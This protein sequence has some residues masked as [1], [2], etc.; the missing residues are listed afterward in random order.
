MILEPYLL[1]AASLFCIGLYGILTS[2]NI[3]HKF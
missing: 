2:R 1:V 3:E